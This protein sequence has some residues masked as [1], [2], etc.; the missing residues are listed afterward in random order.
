MTTPIQFGGKIYEPI[1]RDS[2]GREIFSSRE[3]GETATGYRKRVNSTAAPGVRIR[4][5]SRPLM[6]KLEAEWFAILSAQFPNYPR[7]RAQAKRYKLANGAWYR[8]DVTSSSWPDDGGWAKE[9][10][11]ECKGPKQMKNVARGMLTIRFA[12]AQWPEVAFW[13]VWKEN[14]QW[15]MQRVLP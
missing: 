2:A 11:W 9:T 5:S 3:F 13:L 12:A 8:P 1:G 6:N 7:P 4:Q 15:K 14:G 10:A